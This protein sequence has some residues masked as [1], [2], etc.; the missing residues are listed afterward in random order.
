VP[1]AFVVSATTVLV[2]GSAKLAITTVAM[3]FL[4]IF[5]GPFHT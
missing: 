1:F 2:K 4:F 5:S 3:N